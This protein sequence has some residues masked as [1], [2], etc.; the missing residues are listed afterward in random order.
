MV[1]LLGLEHVRKSYW[2]G[3]HETV[4]LAGVDLQLQAG[5][6]VVIWGQRGAGKTTLARLAAGLEPPDAGAVRFAGEETARTRRAS[7]PLLHREIG[8]VRRVGADTDEFRTV[9]EYVVLPLL[10][11]YSPR[12]ARRVAAAALGRMGVGDCADAEWDSL[13]DGQRTLVS[14][15][16]A[17]IREPRLLIA[18][19]PTAY[20]DALQSDRVMK[21]LR[22]A[23]DEQRIG[24]LVTVPDM[25]DAAYAD[26]IGSLSEGRIVM[27]PEPEPEAQNVIEFP[28]REQSA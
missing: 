1:E 24:A 17:L 28:Q 3:P 8:W 22:E 13:T 27:A 9:A 6:L 20:L 5:E 18:D 26:Q 11:S 19:D 15:A 16:H 23:C 12:E 7:V 21:L 10:S 25:P 4:V 14:I 2:R